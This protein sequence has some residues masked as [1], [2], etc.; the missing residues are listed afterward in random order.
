MLS[1]LAS[2][3]VFKVIYWLIIDIKHKYK[4]AVNAWKHGQKCGFMEFTGISKLVF[5]FFLI[6]SVFLSIK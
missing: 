3:F 1:K 5:Y 6:A 4:Q 2:K